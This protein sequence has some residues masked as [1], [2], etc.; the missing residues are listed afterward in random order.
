MNIKSIRDRLAAL[1]KNREFVLVNDSLTVEIIG[2]SFK[3]N[4]DAIFG[5][6]NEDYIRR[7]ID[8]YESMSR[9]VY[10]IEGKVPKIWEMIS[11]PKG[12]INSN[13]GS[14]IFSSRNYNQY[15][16]VLNTLRK[17]P[18]SRRAVMIYT[19]PRMHEFFNRDGMTDFICTNSVQYVIRK[20]K[21]SAI[22]QMRSNDAWAG[23]RND[24]AWQ[25][26]VLK[27]LA[28]QLKCE[29]GDIHWNAGSLHVYQNQFYLLEHYLQ[30]GEHHITKKEY[31]ALSSP[32]LISSTN[33][34]SR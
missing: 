34:P 5:K 25:K 29:V 26:Y 27:K 13:Y 19:N 4:A 33:H 3:A 21:L 31:E 12:E 1:Y 32:P 7:E 10:D 14:L 2:A 17:D 16:K 28:S 9:N 30:T 18:N 6:P 24:Y 23:Y 8:W 22:V 20:N 15:G 11:S